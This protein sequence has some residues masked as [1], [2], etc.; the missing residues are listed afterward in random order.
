MRAA[1]EALHQNLPPEFRLGFGTG[2]HYG[3]AVLGL[4]GSE[5]RVDYTAIGDSVNTAKRIQE[6]A[7]QG[8]IL[9]SAETYRSVTEEIIV[10]KVEP[11]SAKG[12]SQPVEVFE[13]MGLK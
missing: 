11:V 5:R 4:V 7:T 10:R 12:K 2:I 6:N 3:P 9:I 8:Q 13:V 1:V